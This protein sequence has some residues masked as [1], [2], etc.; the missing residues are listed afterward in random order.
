MQRTVSLWQQAMCCKGLQHYLNCHNILKSICSKA[1]CR[2]EEGKKPVRIKPIFDR[3]S[4]NWHL[5][6]SDNEE[7]SEKG[8]SSSDESSNDGES[9]L[10]NDQKSNYALELP[11]E[12]SAFQPGDYVKVLG[13]SFKAYYAVVTGS[14]YGDEL[15]I[16]YFEKMRKKGNGGPWKRIIWTVEK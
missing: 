7:G 5:R 14:S 1:K 8:N 16:N 10:S 2:N 15:E 6:F 11:E 12:C 4:T 3:A 9:L 13:G